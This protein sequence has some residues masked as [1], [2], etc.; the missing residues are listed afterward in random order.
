MKPLNNINKN[1]SSIKFK[2]CHILFSYNKYYAVN[3]SYL[4]VNNIGIGI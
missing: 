4:F 2:Y 3:F 1:Y